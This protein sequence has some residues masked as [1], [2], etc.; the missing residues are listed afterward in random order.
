M[1]LIPSFGYWVRRQRKAL[2]LTREALAQQVGCA[3][4]TIK[5]IEQDERRPSRQMAQRLAV[6]LAI[7]PE[8][9]SRFIQIALGERSASQLTLP[10]A[11]ISTAAAWPGFLVGADTHEGF[12]GRTRE[13]GWLMTQLADVKQGRGRVVFVTGEAGQGKTA[14]LTQ[15]ARLTQRQ[16]PQLLTA[17]GAG[18]ALGG[19]GDPYQP[20]RDILYQLTGQRDISPTDSPPGTDASQT[21]F[22]AHYTEMLH[23]LAAQRPLL[24]LLDDLQWADTASISL[25]FHLAR[26]LSRQKILII[27]AYRRSDLALAPSGSTPQHPLPPVVNE[28]SRLLGAIQLHLDETSPA[29]GRLLVDALLD[30]EPNRLD[31]AFR[32]ALYRHT[33]GHPLFTVE[34]L[35]DFRERGLLVQDESQTWL[36]R[37]PLDWQTVPARVEAVIAGRI[38]R[39]ERPLQDL[40]AAASV[41]GETFTVQILADLLSQDETTLLR[42]LTGTLAQQHHL[43]RERGEVQVGEQWLTQYQFN[44]ALFQQYLYQRLGQGERRQWHGQIAQRLEHLYQGQSIRITA[45]L[46]HHYAAASQ[47]DRAIPYLLQAG[48][49]ARVQ[50]AY[51]DAIG[52]YRQVLHFLQ[53]KQAAPQAARTLMKLGLTHHLASEFV[54]ARQAYAEGFALWQQGGREDKAVAGLS[55][56]ILRVDWR[57]PMTL[58]PTQAGDFWSAGIIEQL[59]SGLVELTPEL[60]V[61]PDIAES[62]Q[63]EEGGRRYLFHLRPDAKWSDGQPVTAEDFVCAWRRV[64]GQADASLAHVLSGIKGAKAFQQGETADPKTVAIRAVAER[65]LLVELDEP[66]SHF[67]HLL[68]HSATFPVPRHRVQRYGAAWADPDKLVNNGPFRLA[69]WQPGQQMV[70]RRNETYRGRSSG[71]LAQVE[72]CLQ[73][74][75]WGR[76]NL[77]Q[78]DRLD[79][80]RL[81]FLPADEIERQ[82]QRHAG[83]YVSGPQLTTLYVTFNMSRP[84]FNDERVRQAFALAT[85]R[86][87]LAEVVLR[88]YYAPA[89]GGFSP[90]GLPGHSEDAGLP[91]DPVRARQLLAEAG[92]DT[93]P[94]LDFFVSDFRVG[95][96]AFLTQ[97]WREHL[98]AD[99]TVKVRQWS[100]L[101]ELDE[102]KP[103]LAY[104]GWIAD[105]P[106]PDSFL[107][108]CVLGSLEGW[109][110]PTYARLVTQA[111]ALP[112]QAARL[113]LYQQADRLLVQTAA[114]IPLTYGRVHLLVKP[115]VRRFPVS[116]LRVRY[117]KD[118]IMEGVR[119]QTRD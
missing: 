76:L 112:D 118:V 117:W 59:F 22:F 35:R 28:L 83:E 111:S 107:R 70:L 99:V 42:W 41:E 115:W 16:E 71:N 57:D 72:V 73:A 101:A 92:Y 4:V 21:H 31:D 14:L 18:H 39:L 88:G 60:D 38:G 63:V 110:D 75:A 40:L 119:S 36:A 89:L 23:Y 51:Q 67:V 43:V 68:A 50:F 37:T 77:Y 30:R 46:A 82:Q 55:D 5:K 98:G 93:L 114:L 95:D 62:W 17:A 86:E 1:A 53:N 48:D 104:S 66:A 80:F 27:G 8:Q 2:D 13:L 34:L 113:R 6:C 45:T 105:Y 24:L 9:H 85:D 29:E 20:F 94:P 109:Y 58:D 52:Y 84:P 3:A 74:D 7:A 11:P 108:V 87:T 25:L 69:Q 78:Q 54:Q 103:F 96:A 32:A 91:F 81:W 10:A 26:Q 12:V 56:Q 19:R 102:G 47:P 79:V 49:Q 100:A 33:D 15:F 44:H 61:V 65:T 116:A 90:Q 97:Q 106:D 64:L